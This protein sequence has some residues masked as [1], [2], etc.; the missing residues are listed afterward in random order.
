[1]GLSFRDALVMTGGGT[2][3]HFFPAVALAVA[4]KAR[5]PGCPI[6]FVGAKRG[7]E[8]RKLPES[9]WPHL[10]M[11]V[12]GFQ[13]KGL[14]K[15][16]RSLWRMYRAIARLK[17]IWRTE[18]P[19][20]VIGTGGFGAGPALWAAKSLGIPYFIHESNSKP[21]LIV[22]LVAKRAQRVWLGM[23][24]AKASLPK[25]SCLY[26][27]TPIR[28][29]FLRAF[30]P[31]SALQSP[32]KLLVL[33]GSGGAR[34]INNALL[35]F[36]DRLLEKHPDW[37]ITHQVGNLEMEHLRDVQRHPR[38][39]LVS[40]IEQMDIAIEGA[41]LILSRAGA[42]TC[43]ELKTVGRPTVLVPLPKSAGDHQRHNALTFECEGRGLMVEQGDGFEERLQEALSSLMEDRT[44]REALSRPVPN[45]AVALCLD[46]LE[47]D[48]CK[49]DL[50]RR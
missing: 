2:G 28:E 18:R 15:A 6:V 14:F 31:H 38:H 20:A 32:F 47:L 13:G 43:S 21:G 41:S 27:G 8:A 45:T 12:E 44:K 33:G 7:I 23:E 37:E 3:G 26:V 34:A 30:T 17:K 42:S 9:H 29:S 50:L 49:A 11:D 24:A 19:R 22:K 5:W 46:D 36:A 1:M 48:A 16:L 25:A 39:T 10:L 4:T 40:F 35:S